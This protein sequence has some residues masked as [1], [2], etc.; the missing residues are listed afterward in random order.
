MNSTGELVRRDVMKFGALGLIAAGFTAR[1]DKVAA[2]QSQAGPNS[3]TAQ[4]A[5]QAGGP[6]QK[7]LLPPLTGVNRPPAPADYD[8]LPRS[9]NQ[10]AFAKLH[11]AVAELG[12]S[13]VLLRNANNCSYFTGYWFSNT[14]RPQ[15]MFMNAG[16]EA[17]W[18]F[19]PIIDKELIESGWYGGGRAYFDYP[20][21]E[22]AF[23]NEG[24]VST[25]P[26]VDLFEFM[27]EGMK[28]KG[29]SGTKLAIDGE[30]Y[31]SEMAK[32]KKVLPN[33]EVLNV[34]AL[35]RQIR[36]ISTP[37]ELALSARAY[38]FNDRA[39]A[40]ARDYM[41][42]HG[43]DVTDLEI[44]LA[45]TLWL[46]DVVRASLKLDGGLPNRGVATRCNVAV[47]CGRTT[48]YPHPN[49]PYYQRVGKN[50]P[51]QV[52]AVVKVGGCGGENYRMFQIADAAGKFDAHGTRIWE[53]SQ[54][55]C[56]MQMELQADGTKCSEVAAAIHRYQVAEGMQK[57]IYHRPGHGQQSEG[58]YPPY[59]ALGDHTVL[60]KNML[61]SQEPGLYDPEN[62]VG[63]NWSDTIVTGVG[64]GYR[65][66]RVPYTKEWSF[67]R[68]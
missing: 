54:R 44:Q 60:Q 12:C 28:A 2:M 56:D 5:A 39:H 15:A 58:H 49:Q 30:L 1:A 68:L 14:E 18:Y 42:T 62:G 67:V 7:L 8:M 52:V 61:F 66:S 6:S 32:V 55:T 63:Y 59:I 3:L 19:H 45:T 25:G 50:M 37:E 64:A 16:D 11:A 43:T 47:R 48:A 34:G 46:N 13:A 29:I 9:W 51:L 10:R 41:L 38:A 35:V 24:K 27:L 65:M 53:V 40:F 20:H 33:V 22:G 17:P 31:P 36:W 57:Y 21:A 26:T 4:L 23:P